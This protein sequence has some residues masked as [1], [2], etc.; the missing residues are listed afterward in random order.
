MTGRDELEDEDLAQGPALDLDLGGSPAKPT[1]SAANLGRTVGGDEWGEDDDAKGP[2]MDLALDHVT[3]GDLDRLSGAGKAAPTVEQAPS[4]SR[5]SLTKPKTA[6]QKPAIDIDPYEVK[7]LADYGAEPK[8]IVESVPYAIRV[9]MRQ[10]ELKRA[11]E[12]VRKSLAEAESKRDERLI[13]LGTLLEPVVMNNPEYRPVAE[14]I[15]RAKKMVQER[16]A[17]LLDTNAAFREKAAAIDAEIAAIDPQ[18]AAAKREVAAR[19]QAFDEADRLRQKHEARRKRVEIDVRAAQAK[20][21]APASSQADRAQAQQVIGAANQER[22]T[23]AA[24][25]RLAV[26]AAQKVE[27]ELATAKRAE[28]AV[29]GKVQQLRARRKDLEKEFARQGAVRSEG[30]EAA[31]KELRGALLEIGRR[32]AHGGPEAPGADMRRKSVADAES[33]V[34]RLQLDLEKHVRAIGAADKTAV[35]NG[36]V[37]LGAALVILIGGFIAWRALRTNPYLEQPPHSSSP[38]SFAPDK[39]PS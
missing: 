34:K 10:R 2:N 21:D 4:A 18:L 7:A 38:T 33:Q 8:N 30:V 27:A 16:E 28:D 14:P 31:S 32:A 39:L 20:L 23:R 22:E 1:G 13:E 11:L 9:V 37:I 3:G 25:E 36:L 26:A 15:Q 5:V 19:Q 29:D 6:E 24:E 12:G 17:A 35:R